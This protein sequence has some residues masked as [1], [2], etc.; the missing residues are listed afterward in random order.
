[1]IKGIEHSL[2]VLQSLEGRVGKAGIWQDFVCDVLRGDSAQFINEI[3]R[4]LI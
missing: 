1:M 3:E 4:R 2:N